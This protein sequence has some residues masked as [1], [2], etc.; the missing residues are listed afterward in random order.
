VYKF[1]ESGKVDKKQPIP[2]EQWPLAYADACCG[3]EAHDHMDHRSRIEEAHV[4]GKT[5]F[6]AEVR[7]KYEDDPVQL[8]NQLATYPDLRKDNRF[9][10]FLYD[11]A[12]CGD[13][14]FARMRELG[15]QYTYPG[16][17]DAATTTTTTTTASSS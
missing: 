4:K 16:R 2:E 6:E 11:K 13:H 17:G 9:H 15:T 1:K 5:A 7:A 8:S 3:V 14:D 12:M 10:G